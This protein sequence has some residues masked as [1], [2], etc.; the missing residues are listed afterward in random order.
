MLLDFVENV[1]VPS[2]QSKELLKA[3]QTVFVNNTNMRVT[4][5]TRIHVQSCSDSLKKFVP[6]DQRTAFKS[7]ETLL[8][9]LY[10]ILSQNQTE[11]LQQLILHQFDIFNRIMPCEFYHQNWMKPN[12]EILSPNINALT[13]SFNKV[14][15]WIVKEILAEKEQ[16][17]QD[18][19]YEAIINISKSALDNGAFHITFLL[20]T[21]LHN[22]QLKNLC[23]RI[24][25]SSTTQRNKELV[26][27]IVN[28]SGNYGTLRKM[29]SL[30]N[31]CFP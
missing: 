16:S 4:I 28:P 10:E 19:M 7:C 31:P 6:L 13:N 2:L 21:V 29:S 18:Q 5:S 9:T 14:S 20:A 23:K 3:I 1:V 12:K 17:K 8:G 26:D 30:A 27:T 25:L 22:S 11:F 24:S 15:S